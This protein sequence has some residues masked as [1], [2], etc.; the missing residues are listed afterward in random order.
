V[1]T[2][3]EQLKLTIKQAWLTLR[4]MPDPDA[5]YRRA[6]GGGWVLQ[7]VRDASHDFAETSMPRGTPT[8][9]EISIMEAVFEWLSWLRRQIPK[10]KHDYEIVGEY[11]IKRIAA[12]AQGVSIWK[13]AQREHCSDR[14]IQRRI[15]RSIAKIGVEFKDEIEKIIM[16]FQIDE[17][18]I[19]PINEPEPRQERIRGFGDKATAELPDKL[20]P[21]RVYADGSMMFRGEKYRSPY[22]EGG[23]FRAKRRR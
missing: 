17:I 19:P 16:K 5:R 1:N 8:P 4:M 3:L 14:T 6:L 2:A 13:L 23:E 12:W 22:D 7:V 18:E 20:E 11:S 21:G 10:K 15:D 9:R